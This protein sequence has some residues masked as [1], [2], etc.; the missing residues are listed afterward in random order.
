MGELHQGLVDSSNMACTFLS[1]MSLKAKGTGNMVVTYVYNETSPAPSQVYLRTP[2]GIH[3]I[4]VALALFSRSITAPV[5]PPVKLVP[6]SFAPLL[7][8][9]PVWLHD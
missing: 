1:N 8:V 7:P 4:P 2:L 9:N 3:V 6:V 5:P